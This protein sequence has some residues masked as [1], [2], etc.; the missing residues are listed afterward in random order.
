M[1][2]N[3]WNESIFYSQQLCQLCKIAG[4]LKRLFVHTV[5]DWFTIFKEPALEQ[6][7][8]ATMFARQVILP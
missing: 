4:A 3:Y 7:P 5:L 8:P 6:I 1:R 2:V